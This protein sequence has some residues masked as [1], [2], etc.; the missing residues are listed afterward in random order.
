MQHIYSSVC[1]ICNRALLQYPLIYSMLLIKQHKTNVSCQIFICNSGL[2]YAKLFVFLFVVSSYIH[3]HVLGR[4]SIILLEK[5]MDGEYFR[6]CLSETSIYLSVL[7]SQP[8]SYGALLLTSTLRWPEV[9]QFFQPK[10]RC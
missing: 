2:L 6:V 1:S 3:L 10:R 9:A 4:N 8:A 5:Q 7:C